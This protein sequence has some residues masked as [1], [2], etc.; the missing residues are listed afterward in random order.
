[1]SEVIKNVEVDET[2]ET[3]EEAKK[4]FL[5]KVGDFTKKNSKKI[6]TGVAVIAAF[7]VGYNLGKNANLVDGQVIDAV[8]DTVGDVADEVTNL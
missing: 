8:T 4:G 2:E 7:A 5:T 6:A 3:M 1:M